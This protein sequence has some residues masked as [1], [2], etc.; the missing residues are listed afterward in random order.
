MS[1]KEQLAQLQAEN[2]ALKAALIKKNTISCKVSEKGAL[3]VYG[4]QR[5]PVTLYKTQ[6][7]R[8]LGEAKS[9]EAF[10]VA[11]DKSLID[12]KPVV[13]ATPAAQ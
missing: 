6:W 9:I 5:F 4:L 8:L 13:P 7:K 1:D 3:S 12:E 2:A 11:N 10:I